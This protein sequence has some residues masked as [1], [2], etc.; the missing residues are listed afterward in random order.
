[1]TNVIVVMGVSGCGKTTI[2]EALARRLGW[3]YVEGDKLHPP[4]NVEKMRS[5]VPLTDEDRRPWLAAIASHIQQLRAEGHGVVVACSALRQAYREQLRG[6]RSDVRLVYLKGDRDTIAGRLAR[7][8]HAY[9]PASLLASQFAA[10]EEPGPDENPVILPIERSP[11]EIVEA[12][13]TSL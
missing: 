5:G 10:L 11:E 6:G 4:G 2:G 1:M 9:M 12:I 8:S 7:R 13:A 3:R